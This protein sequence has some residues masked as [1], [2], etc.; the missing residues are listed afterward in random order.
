MGNAR[1]HVVSSFTL[2]KGSLIEET[3]KI[4]QDWD[5]SVS[6]QENLRRV[7]E[8]NTI[9]AKSANWA[10]YVAQVLN[11]RFD[12]AG[13]DLP[14][15][16][17]AKA[18][19]SP[20][21]WKP[22]LLWHMTRDEFLLRDFL[23]HWLYPRWLGGTLRVSSADL[24]PYLKSLSRQPGI[25]CS[26]EWSDATTARIASALLRIGYDF[27]LLSGKVARSFASYHLPEASFIY[28]LHAMIDAGMSVS[29]IIESEDWHMY[30]MGSADVERELLRL[31]QFQ[32]LQYNVAGSLAQL[33]LPKGSSGDYAKEIVS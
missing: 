33:D 11:R 8:D 12:P 2:A 25:V 18:H 31:H 1:S 32:K 23:V 30:L 14:L 20:N 10:L 26:G 21:I 9:G 27:G 7:R 15:V 5:F 19:C 17:L 13:R 22:I 16:E 29:G 3:Y 6:R 28:L 24:F 4:F